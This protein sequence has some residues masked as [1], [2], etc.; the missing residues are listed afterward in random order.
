[1][2]LTFIVLFSK[3]K[4]KPKV[5]GSFTKKEYSSDSRKRNRDDKNSSYKPSK[6]PPRGKNRI[7]DTK[8]SGFAKSTDRPSQGGFKRKAS[9]FNNDSSGGKRPRQWTKGS[10]KNAAG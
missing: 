3:P 6:F 2:Q 9:N 5:A 1:M 4:F 8:H 10:K 7:K